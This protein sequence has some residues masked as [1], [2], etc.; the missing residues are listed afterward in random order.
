MSFLP[1]NYGLPALQQTP[2]LLNEAPQPAPLPAASQPAPQMMTRTPV[3]GLPGMAAGGSV[4]PR[5]QAVKNAQMAIKGQHPAPQK[6][7]GDF[8]RAMGVDALLDLKRSYDKGGIV[9]GSGGGVDDLVPASIEGREDIRIAAGEYIIPAR[10]V[11][12]LGDGDSARGAQIL[13]EFCERV[14]SVGASAMA[15]SDPINT[16]ELL[17]QVPNERVPQ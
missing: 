11:S 1:P 16:N 4:A 10:V 9:R 12:A 14:R 13:D 5:E 8:S 6:A 15:G 17:P 2:Q 3:L 7:L